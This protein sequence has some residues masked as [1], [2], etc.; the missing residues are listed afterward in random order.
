MSKEFNRNLDNSIID[1]LQ[2]SDL[3][4]NHLKS[5]CKNQEVF[6]AIRNNEIGFY[7]KGGRLFGYDETNAFNTHF[8]YASVMEKAVEDNYLTETELSNSKLISKFSDNYKQIKDNCERY[9]GDEAKG[10]SEIYRKNSYLS[11]KKIV[12]LDIEV[13]FE[14]LDRTDGKTQDRI[15][16]LLFDTESRKL[17]F[18]EAKHFSNSEIWSRKTPKVIKQ[19]EKYEKQ[20]KVKKTEIIKAYTK[21]I[22]IINSIFATKLPLPVNVEDKVTLLIFDFDRNQQNG[23]LKE[24]IKEKTA[25]N[26]HIVYDIG[27]V[28]GINL[29]NLWKEKPI[30]P[31]K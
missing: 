21:Y 8:K 11:G 15:D 20:I 5:D 18:V 3:W 6:F 31:C 1:E 16:I 10:V 19:I 28:T 30:I 27:D 24:L 22:D 29:E 9:S 17:K 25:Y 13:S 14:A 4:I 12:V 7:R 23:R 2:K 26:G